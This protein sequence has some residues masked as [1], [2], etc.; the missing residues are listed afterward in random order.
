MRFELHLFTSFTLALHTP[1]TLRQLALTET[2]CP[3]PTCHL[4]PGTD[5]AESSRYTPF[6]SMDHT[7]D[8]ETLSRFEIFRLL[9]Y[10]S[11]FFDILSLAEHIETIRN[12]RK[13]VMEAIGSFLMD[14]ILQMEWLS[15]LV[16]GLLTS[17]GIDT[18]TQW[19]GSLQFFLYD[20]VKIVILL[21]VMIFII[22]YVQ[23]FFPPERSKRI[24]GRFKGISGNVIGALLG[25]VTPFCAC[26]SIPLFIAFTRAGL[27][28]GVTFSFLISSPM[29]DLTSLVLV[30]SIFGPQIAIIY[31]IVG[32]V[33]AIVGGTVIDRLGMEGQIQDFVRGEATAITEDLTMTIQERI[34]FAAS[35]TAA[36][37]K[38][39][40][41]FILA[42]VA[43]GAL[44]HNWIPQELIEAILGDGN[45][46]AVILA[47][48]VGA[49]IY[50][51]IFG[52][53]PIAE[54]LY[55]K[56]VG[57]G[58]LLTFMM[59]VTVLS[60]P[61]LT[62]LARVVKPKLLGTFVGVCL[63]GMIASGYL[64]NALQPMFA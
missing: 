1:R 8:A 22:S 55:A 39:V 10:I 14:Q 2:N 4:N 34:A 56:G 30:M 35:S 60:I 51:D 57:L 48:L 9:V 20:T 42:G 61:S 58:T 29:V 59:S 50:A 45:P 25:T 38:K 36:T 64:F 63:V 6:S 54:A 41:P 12:D 27:P 15:A 5:E 18:T 13:V 52:T 40:F 31:T 19:G 16:T 3:N 53:L 44:I 47:A 7:S 62:M 23:S 21:C 49:P 11:S 17:A 43:I 28:L 24:L 33:I 32:L 46:F 26:S 37:F